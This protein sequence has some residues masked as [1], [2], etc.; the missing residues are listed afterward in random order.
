M[1]SLED[2]AEMLGGPVAPIGVA[3]MCHYVLHITAS[4]DERKGTSYTAFCA[5]AGQSVAVEYVLTFG[6]GLNYVFFV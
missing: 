2:P 4:F 3:V 5:S 6:F 1:S